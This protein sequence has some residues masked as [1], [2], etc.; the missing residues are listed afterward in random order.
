MAFFDG[1]LSAVPGLSAVADVFG[2][3]AEISTSKKMQK[4]AHKFTAEQGQIS[5]TFNADEAQK[6]RDFTAD[7]MTRAMDYNTAQRASA[8]QTAVGD[9]KAAGLNPMLAYSQGGASNTPMQGGSGA[10]ASSSPGSGTTSAVPRQRYGEAL[11]S[12]VST[13][14]AVKKILADANVS[15]AQ[16]R[17][18]EADTRLKSQQIDTSQASA[19]QAR[20]TTKK[21]KAEIRRM[22]SEIEN[23]QSQTTRNYSDASVKNVEYS[24]RQAQTAVELARKEVMGKQGSQLEASAALM[25]AQ[26]A[27]QNYRN[28]REGKEAKAHTGWFGDVAPYMGVTRNLG[29]AMRAFKRGR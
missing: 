4:R 24:L 18:V 16:A 19:G 28:V 1:L 2:T 7:Q 3:Q 6:A 15:D 25:R 20:M 22:D 9:M 13:A 8:Y 5:R 29:E 10:S 17:N 27:M 11:M 26:A 21:M 23:L 14:A 12:T